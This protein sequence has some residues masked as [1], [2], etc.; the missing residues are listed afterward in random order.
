MPIHLGRQPPQLRSRVA[1]RLRDG[2]RRSRDQQPIQRLGERRV[3]DVRVGRRAAD[4]YRD[5]VVGQRSG[6]LG[7]QARLARPGFAADEHRL[8]VAVLDPLPGLLER[9]E[10]RGSTD[11][12]AAATCQQVRRKRRRHPLRHGIKVT[13]RIRPVDSQI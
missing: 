4:E 1:K 9:R 3:R 13:A 6:D 5:A 2:T 7:G 12:R 8:A 11:Q 10:L